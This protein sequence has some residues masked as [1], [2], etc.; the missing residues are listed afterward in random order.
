MKELENYFQC[1]L[2]DRLG[3]IT[4]PTRAGDMLYQYTKEILALSVQKPMTP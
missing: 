4:E 1:P 2:L 3:R